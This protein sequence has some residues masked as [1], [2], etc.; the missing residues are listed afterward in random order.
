MSERLP[1]D[2]SCRTERAGLSS[3]SEMNLVCR[4][5]FAGPFQELDLRDQDGVQPPT[6]FHLGRR[7][8]GTPSATLGLGKI[9]EGALLDFQ[10]PELLEQLFA[11]HRP[12]SVSSARAVHQSVAFVLSENQRVERLRADG[13]TR[14]AVPH[15]TPRSGKAARIR[16]ADSSPS[17]VLGIRISH[18]DRLIYPDL[19]ISKIQVARYYEA[20]ADW[21]VP[22][23]AGRPLTLVQSTALK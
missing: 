10:P 18:P 3:R 19:G 14:P 4:R 15:T 12:E 9:H 22:H 7:Q 5:T 23:V 2:Y 1:I 11:D 17:T 16:K 21:I 6:V 13:T 20:I 8:A